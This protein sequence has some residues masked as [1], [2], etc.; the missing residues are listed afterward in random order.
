ME[1][2]EFEFP[3]CV[4]CGDPPN[5]KEHVLPQS[6]I[7][8]FQGD[9]VSWILPACQECNYIAGGNL[10]RTFGDK[11]EYIHIKLK[12]KYK[13]ALNC[14][15]TPEELDE[16]G[17]SLRATIEKDLEMKKWLERRLKWSLKSMKNVGTV[18]KISSRKS[19]GRNSA[20]ET[21]RQEERDT[22]E[23]SSI[24]RRSYNSYGER[25]RRKGRRG[26]ENTCK[27][28]GELFIMKHGT[29]KYCEVECRRQWYREQDR[30]ARKL[31]KEKDE[32]LLCHW[33]RGDR[34]EV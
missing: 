1:Y 23:E 3:Y 32:P 28:C 20:R 31:M 7:W 9:Y 21:Q 14:N 4:Y 25:G 29:E 33:S 6:K 26:Q 30:Q 16:L 24:T 18:M 19:R 34:G 8:M 13:I 15:W 2:K 5:Q 22:A 12:K 27:N 17:P 11:T 10:F